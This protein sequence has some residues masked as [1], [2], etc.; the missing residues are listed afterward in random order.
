MTRVDQERRKNEAE[1]KRLEMERGVW[2]L[3]RLQAFWR[4]KCATAKAMELRQKRQREILTRRAMET[5]RNKFL[6]ERQ[7]YQRQLEKFY[8]SMKEEES[9][10]QT[11]ESK[12][13][14]DQIKVRTLRRRL[15]NEEIKSLP[16]DMTEHFATEAW[17]SDWEARIEAGVE[18]TKAS[19]IQCLDRPDN[20]LEKKTRTSIRKR[21]KGRVSAVLARA[22]QQGIPMETK[23][24]KA[25]AREEIMHMIGEEERARLRSEMETAFQERTRLKEEERMQAEAKARAAHARATLYAVSIVAVA[26]V[27]FKAVRAPEHV[28]SVSH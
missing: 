9:N 26:E 23:E 12:V 16:P 20:S 11:I 10:S 15:K 19:S 21:I 25:I 14:H 18:E 2:C 28:Q 5:E 8:Q 22:D 1:R 4:R 17:K 3:T 7:I 24:A 6:R 13:A 27:S